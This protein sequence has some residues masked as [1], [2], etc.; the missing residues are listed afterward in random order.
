MLTSLLPTQVLPLRA[1]LSL[2]DARI[3]LLD[4]AVEQ[5]IDIRALA[6]SNMCE[7]LNREPHGHSPTA[8]A[9]VLARMVEEGDI[10]LHRDSS[11]ITPAVAAS[12]TQIVETLSEPRKTRRPSFYRLTER[13]GAEWEEWAKPQW[14]RYN[15]SCGRSGRT[16]IAAATASVAEELL[17]LHE[18]LCHDEVIVER[19]IRRR[20]FRNWRRPIGRRCL[21]A[22]SSHFE[23][24]RRRAA[25]GARCRIASGRA[26]SIG[27][28]STSSRLTAA[29]DLTAPTLRAGRCQLGRS[30]P[31]EVWV[32]I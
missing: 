23:L 9:L 15:T 22:T 30:R 7:V 21:E 18:Y 31:R 16:A 25:N 8:V 2:I 13:G 17:E 11:P 28:D 27:A 20:T 6:A 5:G 3:W 10:T 26:G 1:A 14:S 4:A 24:S 32:M 12:Q 29:F 19:S